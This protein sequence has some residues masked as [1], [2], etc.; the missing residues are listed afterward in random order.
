MTDPTSHQRGCP[1]KT[2]HQLSDNNIWT[3][4]NMWSQVQEWARRLDVQADWSSVVTWL[5]RS[6]NTH[7]LTIA[8][9]HETTWL[10]NYP[11]LCT[12]QVNNMGQTVFCVVRAKQQYRDC[13]E[14]GLDCDLQRTDPASRRRGCLTETG[15]Q[16]P[17]PNPW[18]GSNIWSN[19]HK[20]GSTPRH[21]DWLTDWLSVTLR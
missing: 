20:V 15:Q 2:K 5:R 13:W 18:K 7:C 12:S 9:K 19:I 6:L 1:T 21:T 3:E 11:L 10:I 8:G 4:S 14:S 16:I 17:D